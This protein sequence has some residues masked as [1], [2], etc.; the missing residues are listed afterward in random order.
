MW[1]PMLCRME[2][3]TLT[4]G[5]DGKTNFPYS[6]AQLAAALTQMINGDSGN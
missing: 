2:M 3:V 1:K 4:K 5:F 6:A